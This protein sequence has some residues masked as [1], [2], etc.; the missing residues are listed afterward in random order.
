MVNNIGEGNNLRICEDV[1]GH[2]FHI[3]RKSLTFTEFELL[4]YFV[5]GRFDAWNSHMYFTY[6][7]FDEYKNLFDTCRTQVRGYNKKRG[8]PDEVKNY[9]IAVGGG[10]FEAV[11]NYYA[12]LP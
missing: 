1:D 9:F 3:T 4:T 8:F 10:L 11:F 5:I 12:K 7:P 6:I 2:P